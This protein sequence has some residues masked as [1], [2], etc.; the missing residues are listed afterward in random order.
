MYPRMCNFGYYS[1]ESAGMN[2]ICT[3]CDQGKYCNELAIYD[4]STLDCP[5]GYNC[6]T[7]TPTQYPNWL[8]T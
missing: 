1:D 2:G 3:L 6:V 5:D 8:S 7:G 4:I